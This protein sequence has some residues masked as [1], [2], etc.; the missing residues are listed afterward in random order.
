MA[1]KTTKKPLSPRARKQD[2]TQGDLAPLRE[3]IAELVG[4][5][6]ALK[7]ADREKSIRL[8]DLEARVEELE[9]DEHDTIVQPADPTADGDASDDAD[10]DDETN[11]DEEEG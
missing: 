8:H 5:V 10:D 11:D 7:K 1:K 2:A 6:A 3:K 4:E 9:S